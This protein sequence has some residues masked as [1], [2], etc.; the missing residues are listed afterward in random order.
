MT[1]DRARE[2]APV[3]DRAYLEGQV[4]IREPADRRKPANGRKPASGRKPANGRRPAAER[5]DEHPEKILV[6]DVGGSYLKVLV[7]G[8]TEPR[9]TPSGKKLTPA[10]LV[11]EVERLA[12]DWKYDA[13]TVGFPGLTGPTGPRCEPGNLGKGWV[14]FD[15]AAAFDRPVKVAN[16]AAMQA[17]GSY[18]GGRMLFLGLG[19]GLGSAL[20]ADHTII[21]LELGDLAWK[22]SD[23]QT[24]GDMLSAAGL[25]K[26]GVR[27]WKKNVATAAASLMK[28]FLAD[29]LVIGGGNAK[30]LRDL[31]HGMRLGHNQTAFRGGFRL[32]TLEDVPVLTADLQAKPAAQH[33]K[34]R[35][36]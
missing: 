34:W 2:V 22:G 10:K 7:S 20:I 17:L 26:A 1:T 28:A 27:A 5:P 30:K 31:P 32:W 6:V 35:M 4:P 3:T 21:S 12:K 16:D 11:A 25:E 33:L 23:E 18:D 14:G 19:T 13:V 8:E 24:L 15:F 9:R 36:L 29:Y